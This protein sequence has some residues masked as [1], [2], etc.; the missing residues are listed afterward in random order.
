VAGE[1]TIAGRLVSGFL[2]EIRSGG[3]YGGEQGERLAFS[4]RMGGGE[5]VRT[6]KGGPEP[7][8]EG[9]RGCR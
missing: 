5:G 2:Q 7:I 8:F 3:C 9:E 1:G 6:G 4:N